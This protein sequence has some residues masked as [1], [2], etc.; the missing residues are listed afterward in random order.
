MPTTRK[1]SIN[2]VRL[3][4]TIVVREG[5]KWIHADGVIAVFRGGCV[6]ERDGKPVLVTDKKVIITTD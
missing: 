2:K 4:D 5:R 3:H 6:V 1:V